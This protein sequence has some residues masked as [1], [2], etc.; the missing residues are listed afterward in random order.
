MGKKEL[1]GSSF[2]RGR[3]RAVSFGRG[4]AVSIVGTAVLLAVNFGS[5]A[6][7]RV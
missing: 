5:D 1:E 7:I 6:G 4:F 2:G 3:S